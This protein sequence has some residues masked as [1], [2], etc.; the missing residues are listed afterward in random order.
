MERWRGAL[1]SGSQPGVKLVEVRSDIHACMQHSDNVDVA[2]LLVERVEDD[3]LAGWN[4][5]VSQ[6]NIGTL[7]AEL[8]VL[9]QPVEG[10]FDVAQVGVRLILVP[11]F[12][13]VGPDVQKMLFRPWRDADISHFG[14]ALPRR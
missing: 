11:L 12:S 8:G 1:L 7:D 5:S 9:G 4:G 10:G 2:L 14:V 13:R 6:G 3:M